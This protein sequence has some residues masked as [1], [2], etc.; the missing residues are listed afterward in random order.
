MLL[1][2]KLHFGEISKILIRAYGSQFAKIILKLKKIFFKHY[3][4]YVAQIF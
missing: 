3:K 4:R 2:K 1:K